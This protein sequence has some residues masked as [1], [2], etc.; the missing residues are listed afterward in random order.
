[1]EK[2]LDTM[3]LISVVTELQAFGRGVIQREADVCKLKAICMI[4][5][6]SFVWR[7]VAQNE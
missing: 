2:I 4:Q 7:I 1:M 5:S 6:N 3:Q